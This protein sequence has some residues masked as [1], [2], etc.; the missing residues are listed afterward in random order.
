VKEP[1]SVSSARLIGSS[2]ITITRGDK[3]PLP[4]WYGAPELEVAHKFA[5]ELRQFATFAGTWE[6]DLTHGFICAAISLHIELDTFACITQLN[7][8]GTVNLGPADWQNADLYR[9]CANTLLKY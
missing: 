2:T 5:E 4:I 1:I 6:N 7:T 3:L 8:E 9:R